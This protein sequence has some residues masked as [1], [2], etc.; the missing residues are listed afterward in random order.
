MLAS[1]L[2]PN[3]VAGN[4]PDKPVINAGTWIKPP[5]PATAST[6]PAANAASKSNTRSGVDTPY[7]PMQKR[8]NISPNRSSALKA[9]VIDANCSCAKRNSSAQNSI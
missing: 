5:P 8:E 4:S 9:P 2:V 7:L 6:K 1:L 3:T